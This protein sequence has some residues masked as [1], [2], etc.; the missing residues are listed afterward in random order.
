MPLEILTNFS[1]T[2]M[3]DCYAEFE[4]I[5]VECSDCIKR[6]ACCAHAR[7]KCLDLKADHPQ[8]VATMLAQ[9]ETKLN[10][11]DVAPARNSSPTGVRLRLASSF[12]AA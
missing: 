12:P 11:P 2:V 6:A 9:I 7:R 1:G 3:A 4:A 8:V 5:T 10:E